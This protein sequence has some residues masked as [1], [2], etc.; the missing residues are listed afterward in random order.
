MPAVCHCFAEAV[1][2]GNHQFSTASAKQWH[3]A[4]ETRENKVSAGI[5]G[6]AA[7]HVNVGWPGAMHYYDYML[8]AQN[9]YPS[10]D[11]AIRL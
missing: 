9:Y 7:G 2:S 10:L 1:P 11:A 5:L 3:T 8:T 6:S 4:E